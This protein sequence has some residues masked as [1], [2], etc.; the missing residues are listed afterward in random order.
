V[1]P[2]VP[3][4]LSVIE[5]SFIEQWSDLTEVGEMVVEGKVVR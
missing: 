4:P 3:P 5:N 2:L 1:Q